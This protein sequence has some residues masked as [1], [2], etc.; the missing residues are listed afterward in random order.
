MFYVTVS[1]L[2]SWCLSLRCQLS[3]AVFEMI[4]YSWFVLFHKK[5]DAH[6]SPGVLVIP[7]SLFAGCPSVVTFHLCCSVELFYTS[8][9]QGVWL[10]YLPSHEHSPRPSCP[11][12]PLTRHVGWGA[13]PETLRGRAGHT[14][15]DLR[16]GR[17][18]IPDSSPG[19]CCL[20]LE[21][22]LAHPCLL[23]LAPCPVA[24]PC[25]L[26]ASLPGPHVYFPS[27]L[28]KYSGL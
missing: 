25:L 12:F 27:H 24:R 20:V 21:L 28:L 9:L 13:L 19:L 26:P 10:L 16:T 1:K 3:S 17:L 4:K 22:L 23:I 8:F 11:L 15:A 7:Q 6:P 14:G 5:S 2:S 18:G